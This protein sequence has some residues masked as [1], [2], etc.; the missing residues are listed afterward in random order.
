[1]FSISLKLSAGERGDDWGYTAAAL[2]GSSFYKLPRLLQWCTGNIGFHHVHHLFP[3]IPNYYLEQCHLAVPLFKEVPIVTLVSSFRT[4]KLKLWD[5]SSKR[6]V[7]FCD[8]DELTTRQD[9]R[10]AAVVLDDS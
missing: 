6:L 10:A 9:Q 2:H 3:R 5:E 1:M 4:I 7:Q 8:L